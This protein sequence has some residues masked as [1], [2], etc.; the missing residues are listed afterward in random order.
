MRM[1]LFGT[2]Q[3]TFDMGLWIHYTDV[4]LICLYGEVKELQESHRIGNL[5]LLG[6]CSHDKCVWKKHKINN[7]K[8][9]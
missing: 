7:T 9:E 2:E 1:I 5:V 4:T 6:G 3:F 8:Y